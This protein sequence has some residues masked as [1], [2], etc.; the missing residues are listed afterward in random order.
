MKNIKFTFITLI[1]LLFFSSS[2]VLAVEEVPFEV[3]KTYV[4]AEATD[5]IG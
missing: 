5:N 2:S 3:V 4:T 1:F